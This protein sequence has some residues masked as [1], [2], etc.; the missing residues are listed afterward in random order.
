MDRTDQTQSQ[1]GL[2]EWRNVQVE[3]ESGI[4]WVTMSRPDKRNCMNPAMN[5]EMVEVL[6]AIELESSAACWC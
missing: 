2:R 1:R 5:D 4:A 6:D 3:I